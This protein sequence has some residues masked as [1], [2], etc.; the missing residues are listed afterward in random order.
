ML[1]HVTLFSVFA[2]TVTLLAGTPLAHAEECGLKMYASLDLPS[3][4]APL[5]R[6]KIQGQSYLMA[7]DTSASSSLLSKPL[8]DELH[9]VLRELPGYKL[10]QGTQQ[11][12]QYAT[13]PSLILGNAVMNNPQIAV[14]P[15]WEQTDFVGWIGADI[16]QN[17]DME[18]DFSHKKIN[19]FSP[20]HCPGQVVYWTNTYTSIAYT[21]GKWGNMVFNAKADDE[22]VEAT[23][24]TGRS[25]SSLSIRTA[26]NKLNIDT[27]K[28]GT[29]PF[30]TPNG[31]GYQSQLKKIAFG[32]I[33]I[34]NPEVQLEPL[35][36]CENQGAK[37]GTAAVDGVVKTDCGLTPLNVGISILK[38]LRIYI[39][40]K[41]KKIYI[42]DADAK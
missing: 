5:V 33:T 7:F 1:R 24:S 23:I 28:A 27:D 2:A 41:E 16:L 32:G 42:S 38:K 25:I 26:R 35:A 30:L 14:V 15:Q 10:T 36:F 22:D 20:D 37:K 29:D 9:L 40:A 4:D 34:L 8:A 19:L 11:V 31:V 12:T 21:K 18:V 17:L 6:V 13:V 3:P 39:A